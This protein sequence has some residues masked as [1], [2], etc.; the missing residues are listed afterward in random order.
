MV[1]V[2]EII[3]SFR[4]KTSGK[5]F[6][7]IDIGSLSYFLNFFLN[8]KCHVRVRDAEVLVYKHPIVIFRVKPIPILK[9]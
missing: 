6:L 8:N 2:V 5:N 9:A 4:V 7:F 1:P 3:E